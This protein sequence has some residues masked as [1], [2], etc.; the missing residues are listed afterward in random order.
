LA[1]ELRLS[2]RLAPNRDGGR[3]VG[4]VEMRT[5]GVPETFELEHDT[6]L[7]RRVSG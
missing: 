5:A 7:A 4:G 1:A 6:N 3:G 2:P